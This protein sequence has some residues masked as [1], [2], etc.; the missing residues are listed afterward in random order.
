MYFQSKANK[1]WQ[2]IRLPKLPKIESF[3][4]LEVKYPYAAKQLKQ[5][6]NNANDIEIGIYKH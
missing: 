6:L 2:S 5:T 4:Q 3:E 1:C